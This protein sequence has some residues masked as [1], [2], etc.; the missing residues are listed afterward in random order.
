VEFGVCPNSDDERHIPP[1]SPF[2]SIIVPTKDSAR[3]TFLLDLS[4]RNNYPILFCGPTGTNPN[5]NPNPGNPN[6]NPNPQLRQP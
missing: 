1:G 6:P 5:P 3:Y 4:V 2:S